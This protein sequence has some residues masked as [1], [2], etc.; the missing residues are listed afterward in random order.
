M[1]TPDATP[2]AATHVAWPS[3]W[4]VRVVDETGSTNA[5]LL[6]AAAAGAPDRSVL[7]ARYQSAGRGR[8]DRR[9]ESP[10]GANLLVSLL[11]R[12][13]PANPHELTHRVALA[14]LDAIE[15]TTGRRASLKWP[16][17]LLL[18]G[19][20]LAGLLAQSGGHGRVEYVVVGLGL[21]VGWS[22]DG[23][24]SLDGAVSPDAL[25]AALLGAFDAL[26]ADI[27]ARYRQRLDTL[28]RQVRV[29]RAEGDVFGRAVDLDADGRLVVLDDCGL[30]HHIDVG[31]VV[32]LR[33]A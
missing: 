9:W 15:A 1:S 4:H 3:G 5:D 23:A 28:G 12:E 18:D 20:K 16:N 2:P 11:F 14:A 25:L 29:Q 32:H 26:P 33:E 31:D 6:L 22:I 10:P 21:N 7:S 17:D 8:L 13:V 24:A 19:A 27:A 30:S